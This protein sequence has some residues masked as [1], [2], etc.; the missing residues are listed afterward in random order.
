MTIYKMKNNCRSTTPQGAVRKQNIPNKTNI[1]FFFKE[2]DTKQKKL[3]KS[4][5]INNPIKKMIPKT[6]KNVFRLSL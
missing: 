2:L 6:Q 3:S 1:F 5:N 4:Y